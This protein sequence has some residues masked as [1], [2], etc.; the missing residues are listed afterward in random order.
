MDDGV[1]AIDSC[2]TPLI[3]SL[4]ASAQHQAPLAK[5]IRQPLRDVRV[6]VLGRAPL[7]RAS[8]LPDNT[9]SVVSVIMGS[10]R[11][12]DSR[13]SMTRYSADQ[14][15]H[16]GGPARESLFRPPPPPPR[17]SVDS[18]GSVRGSGSSINISRKSYER[19]TGIE[20]GEE[21][22]A[23]TGAPLPPDQTA[24]MTMIPTVRISDTDLGAGDSMDNGGVRM[25]TSISRGKIP[26]IDVAITPPDEDPSIY[27][28]H[29]HHTM[30][31]VMKVPH[32][33]SR[34]GPPLLGRRQNKQFC[35]HSAGGVDLP[36]Q[37]MFISN[38]N[39]HCPVLTITRDLDEA[40]LVSD[41]ITSTPYPLLYNKD[42]SVFHNL[43]DDVSL[44]G[45]RR[46]NCRR[47]GRRTPLAS[48]RATT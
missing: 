25:M 37:D 21:A 40:S 33:L 3:T 12:S 20:P 36:P 32:R 46:K 7:E 11:R 1:T 2:T 26:Q 24:K 42:S 27:P 29:Q 13:R 38:P 35:H 16:G 5:C 17:R 44:Y 4:S 19:L 22:A 45:R 23:A 15:H 31:G 10:C 14:G 48:P 43:G 39:V 41:Y 9:R 18:A 28:Y 47:S 30:G 8:S 34:T 6:A